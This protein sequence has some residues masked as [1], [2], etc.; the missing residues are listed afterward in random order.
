MDCDW[1]LTAEW[2]WKGM[3]S[4]LPKMWSQLQ[5]WPPGKLCHGAEAVN[6]RRPRRGQHSSPVRGALPGSGKGLRNFCPHAD[7]LSLKLQTP[8]QWLPLTDEIN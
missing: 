2:H 5:A 7:L 8:S 3:A 6:G 1:N 4:L